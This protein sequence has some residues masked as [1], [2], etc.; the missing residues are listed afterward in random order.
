MT[1]LA[2]PA[3]VRVYV[4]AVLG[5]LS[6]AVGATQV[7]YAAINAPAPEWLTVALA[8][9]PFLAAGLGY[10][11]ATHTPSQDAIIEPGEGDVIEVTPGGD[12]RDDDGDGIADGAVHYPG[13]PRG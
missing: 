12:H 8:V 13:E 3:K 10:T 11:A 7:G 5:V 9:V 1:T 4:Y 2:M 6:L